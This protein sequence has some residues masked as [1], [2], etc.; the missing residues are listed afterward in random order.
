MEI[1]IFDTS[2][3]IVAERHYFPNKSKSDT[4]RLLTEQEP[5]VYIVN[6]IIDDIV[7]TRKLRIR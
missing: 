1:Q 4:S 3:K 7:K 2:G 5:G 6:I